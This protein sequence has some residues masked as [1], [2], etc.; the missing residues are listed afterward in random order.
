LDCQFDQEG[1]S[2]RTVNRKL[3]VLRSYYKFLVRNGIIE[4]LPLKEHKALKMASKVP[5]PFSEEEV[6]EVL[7][8]DFYPDIIWDP[9]KNTLNLFYLHWDSKE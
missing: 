5:L 3:S 8:G 2:T 4:V 7:E 6:L 1:N 9:S